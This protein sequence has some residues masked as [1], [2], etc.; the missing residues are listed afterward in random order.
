MSAW[1]PAPS[2]IRV[3]VANPGELPAIHEINGTL[4]SFQRLLCG[5][6]ELVRG[7]RGLDGL[8][9]FVNEDGI[10]LGLAANRGFLGPIVVSASDSDGDVASLTDR[11][12]ARAIAALGLPGDR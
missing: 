6:L 8:D 2:P 3:V 9:V 12:C 10:R 5:N 7:V 4:S 1:A 11:E